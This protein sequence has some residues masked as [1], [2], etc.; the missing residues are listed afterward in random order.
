M[1]ADDLASQRTTFGDPSFLPGLRQYEEDMLN[2]TI[3]SAIRDRISDLHTQNI[4][5]YNPDGLE[6]LDT[7]VQ[8]T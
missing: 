1:F 4:S 8:V 2:D 5:A 3:A 6:S 7:Y